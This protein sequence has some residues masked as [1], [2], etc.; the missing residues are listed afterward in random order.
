MSLERLIRWSSAAAWMIASASCVAPRTRA[1]PDARLTEDEKI[2]HVLARLTFGAR[3]GDAA[4]VR[5]MGIDRWI[6]EQLHPER[7]TDTAVTRALAKNWAWS[8]DPSRVAQVDALP[9]FAASR[10]VMESMRD[11]AGAAARLRV[12][13]QLLAQAR[14]DEIF[15]AGR[16]TQ[17]QLTERQLFEVV[18]AFWENH[19]TVWIGKMPA[20]DAIIV[21]D[22]AAI[23]PHALGRFR[24]LLGAV[25]HSPA[26]LY[27]LDN[28][29]STRSGLNENY[30]RELLELHTLGVDGG[31]TQ[32]DVIEVA[33]AFTGW[34][35]DRRNDSTRFA[36][37][38][39]L[40]DTAAKVVLGHRLAP[41]R[42]I[43]D[44][45]EVLDIL[46]RHPSTARYVSLKLARRLVSDD[47]P[48]TL[49]DRATA[50]FRRSDGDIA[51]VVRTIVTSPEF[52]TRGAVGAKIKT[53]FEYI[54]SVRR[55]VNAPIDTGAATARRLA[56]LGQPIFGWAT[57]EGWPDRGPPWMTSGA[58]YTRLQYAHDAVDARLGRLER[59]EPWPNLSPLDGVQQVRGVL[60]DILG[61]STDDTVRSTLAT[62]ASDSTAPP[63]RLRRLVAIALAS[64][65]F[66]R[67]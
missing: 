17:A 66:Q 62:I 2:A 21:W 42:G 3:P 1:M 47:P 27:Y 30:A 29:L 45:E 60:D 43:E 19:F 22:R 16:I 31:Y 55:A 11:T 46:A 6:D 36:F 13:A 8:A 48:S 51:E 32:R 15:V 64:P 25:A 12:T 49:V 9:S 41:G 40:H 10:P 39:E 5:A 50:A 59:W 65:A 28:P 35:I 23:R 24:D 44:G 26:M 4:R 18:T 52:F 57:P 37:K 33:R 38:R 67:R 61:G 7:I 58:L 34:T 54:V 14:L 63:D 53:P 56:A 20:R